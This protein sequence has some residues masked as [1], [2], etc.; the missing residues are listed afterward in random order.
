MLFPH[1]VLRLIVRKI[2]IY[3]F[4]LPHFTSVI[5]VIHFTRSV[6]CISYLM[7]TSWKCNIK[8]SWEF[9]EA[10]LEGRSSEKNMNS[11]QIPITDLN[12]VI[13]WGRQLLLLLHLSGPAKFCLVIT[14]RKFPRENTGAWKYTHINSWSYISYEKSL[15]FFDRWFVLMD[16]S[17]YDYGKKP[18]VNYDYKQMIFLIFVEIIYT[19][20]PACIMRQYVE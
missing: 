17:K 12:L 9:P 20:T 14:M 6:T 4:L 2:W 19:L 16:N 1:P 15:I 8:I 10:L 13:H 11:F 18:L 3:P 5:S 7:R